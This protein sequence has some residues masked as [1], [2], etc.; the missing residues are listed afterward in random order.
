MH[1]HNP[2]GAG[3]NHGE[4]LVASPK[5]CSPHLVAGGNGQP[6]E[7]PPD[8][9]GIPFLQSYFR[10]EWSEDYCV[11]SFIVY[12]LNLCLFAEAYLGVFADNAVYLDD[13]LRPVL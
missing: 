4:F 1:D 7:Q 10:S 8:V 2:L 13:F 11:G 9:P 12:L 3:I 5:E 6:L